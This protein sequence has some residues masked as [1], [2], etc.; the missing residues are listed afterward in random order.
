MSLTEFGD[1]II[2]ASKPGSQ[3]ASG[4]TTPITT[5][6]A[7]S[8]AAAAV[9][10]GRGM[11]SRNSSLTDMLFNIPGSVSSTTSMESCE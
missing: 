2:L 6:Q 4:V 1:A 9:T 8:P 10:G 7:P 5:S 3:S 11:K